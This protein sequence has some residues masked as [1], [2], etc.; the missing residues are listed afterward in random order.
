MELSI[1]KGLI[2]YAYSGPKDESGKPH[3]Y[4]A[5]EYKNKSLYEGTFSH[6]KRQG[7]GIFYTNDMVKNPIEK[8]E[9]YQIGDYD[10]AGRLIHPENPLGS[11]EPY[12]ERLCQKYAGWWKNDE[13]IQITSYSKEIKDI[14]INNEDELLNLF[15]DYREVLKISPE[16]VDK[17]SKSDN[18]VCKYAYG[19]CLCRTHIDE[20]SL[21]TAT[22]CFRYASDNGVADAL[23]MLSVLYYKGEYYDEDKNA[24]VF[25]RTISHTLNEEAIRRGSMLAKLIRNQH[26]FLG[27]EHLAADEDAAI[28]EAEAEAEANAPKASL[29][30]LEQLGWFYDMQKKYDK[31]IE[32]YEKCIEGG[33]LYPFYDLALIYLDLNKTEHYDSLM[34]EGIKKNVPKCMAW[35]FEHNTKWDSL[36]SKEQNKIHRQL[37]QN[38]ETGIEMGDGICAFI[39]AYCYTYGEMGFDQ[40][41]KKGFNTALIGARLHDKECC[42]L[43]ADIMNDKELSEA[44]PKNMRM[45]ETDILMMELRA[46]RYGNDDM[47]DR[48]LDNADAYIIM[49]YQDEIE[50]V[51]EPRWDRLNDDYDDDGRYDAWA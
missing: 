41:L 40:N 17:L 46:L 33:L 37:R 39:L 42:G 21:K 31:A 1:L 43:I 29:L 28:A 26:L 27:T 3:G 44:L 4:G 47:L 50:S 8:W 36:D 12:V 48:V 9:W 6:G 51:W 16:I 5:L 14:D 15:L 32:A 24:L 2:A 11:Y 34:L 35:G 10:A 38:L 13:P 7:F 45:S 20:K 19:Q 22:E 23:A 25:D 30:W 18:P 49:G